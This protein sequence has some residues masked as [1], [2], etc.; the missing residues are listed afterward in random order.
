MTFGKY[1]VQARLGLLCNHSSA[2]LVKLIM[3]IKYCRNKG[4]NFCY[5]NNTA[6][7]CI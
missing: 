1:L 3:I 5:C 2:K 6:Y 7:H 4:N